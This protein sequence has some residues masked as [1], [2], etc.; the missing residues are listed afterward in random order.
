MND[1]GGIVEVYAEKA[2]L[3]DRC[4]LRANELLRLVQSQGCLGPTSAL[5]ISDTGL[6]VICL[7]LVRI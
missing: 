7:H 5:G 3:S 2:G 4:V 6:P 1:K